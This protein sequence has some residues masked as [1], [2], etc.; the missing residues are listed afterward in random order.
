MDK[1]EGNIENKHTQEDLRIM[2]AWPL[3]RK[4]RVT[5]TR[6][7]EWYQ[8]WEGQVYV[9]FSGGKDSTVLLD[10]ARRIYPDLPA[11]FSD[12]GLEFPEIRK[13]VAS[14]KNVE[15]VVPEMRFDK[16]VSEYGYPIIGKKQARFIR[17]LKNDTGNNEVTKNMRITGLNKNGVMCPSMKLAKKWL[18]LKDA[19][20]KI[21][22]Q[23]CDITKKKPLK[24]YEKR[25]GRHP[26]VGT[27]CEESDMR[28][29][30]WISSGCNAFDA[31]RPISTPMA[32]WTEQD[33]LHY[34]KDFNIPYCSVYG[35]I[36][37]DDDGQLSTT[38]EHRT[39]CMFCMF[40]VQ[41]DK[42]PNRFQRMK[43]THP[44]QY[45][46]C[47]KPVEDGGLG[48]SAVLDYIGIKYE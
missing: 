38:G 6:I 19:P 20:F 22:E 41:F 48:L 21:S 32:F 2:Q 42:E 26:I 44:K 23:C 4:I 45:E 18:Y 35:D 10:L 11:V 9:S 13:F 29:K 3:E 40:G 1:E 36:V 43:V 25:T 8:H 47:M 24:Q 12:T 5:Q 46:Y 28:E 33:V 7:I 39:G 14:I 27:M 15:R 16:V 30:I 17:D 31:K 37:E 34:L